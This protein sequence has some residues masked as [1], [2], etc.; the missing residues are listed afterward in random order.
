MFDILT[1]LF[2]KT[3]FDWLTRLL[4]FFARDDSKKC[5]HVTLYNCT[6]LFACQQV[7]Y[8]FRYFVSVWVFSWRYYFPLDNIN[9]HCNTSFAIVWIYRF[10]CHCY[11]SCNTIIRYNASQ[12]N[13]NYFL[14]AIVLDE[15]G[16]YMYM[17]KLYLHSHVWDDNNA[18]YLTQQKCI[19]KIE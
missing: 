4:R 2:F 5:L 12:R 10:P 13:N 15:W 18:H 3:T 1:C 6:F 16:L 11:F 19:I 8:F 9:I 7:I 17:Y 14:F